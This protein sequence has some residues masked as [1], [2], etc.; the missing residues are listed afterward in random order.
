MS[1]ESKKFKHLCVGDVVCVVDQRRRGSLEPEPRSEQVVRVGRKFGYIKGYGDDRPFDLATG[2]SHHKEGNARANGYGFDVYKSEADYIQEVF[3]ASEF[4]RLKQRLISGYSS[5]L[6]NL[7]HECV[8]K[9][10]AVL[11]E[12]LKG[13]Q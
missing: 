2:V 5:S 9:I 8:S 4:R 1:N 7:S 13:E 11:D 6:V 10:H 12:E 3:R